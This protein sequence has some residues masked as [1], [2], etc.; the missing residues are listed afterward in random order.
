MSS[1]SVLEKAFD[2]KVREK[3]AVPGRER[4]PNFW[5][6][7]GEKKL[8]TLASVKKVFPLIDID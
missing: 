2:L 7:W 4:A 1:K 6:F 5:W 3:P 8:S